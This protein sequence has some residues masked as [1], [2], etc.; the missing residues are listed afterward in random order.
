MAK[1]SLD[2][3]TFDRTENERAEQHFL[4]V[5]RLIAVWPA[6]CSRCGSRTLCRIWSWRVT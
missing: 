6:L 2:D 1:V 5:Q 3:K 4:V